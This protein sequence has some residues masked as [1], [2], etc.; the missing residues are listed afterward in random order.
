MEIK[1]R[2]AEEK[3]L[4]RIFEI[5]K[6]SYPPELR[7]HN[8]ILRYRFETFGIWVAEM[9]NKAVGFFTCVPIKLSWPVPRIKEILKNRI[10]CYK[11]WFDEYKR[12]GKFDTL[13]ITSTAV[14]S[15]YQGKGAGEALITYSLQLA[16]KLGLSYRASV[17]RIPGYRAYYKK[18]SKSPEEYIKEIREGRIRNPLLN[19]YLKLGFELGRTIPN[20]EPDRESL[21]YGV[22]A[23]KKIS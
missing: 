16:K 17:L 1:I 18:T 7:A 13:Y 9:D 20:Y 2:K 14:E 5:E 11:P 10:P 23:Y 21:D 3:D 12:K 15:K 4:E 19:L 8:Q 22:F 6:R